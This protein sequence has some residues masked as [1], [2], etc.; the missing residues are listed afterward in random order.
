MSEQREGSSNTIPI[1]LAALAGGIIGAA[2]GIMLAPKAG[3]ELR[4]DLSE[5]AKETWDHLDIIEEGKDLLKDLRKALTDLR[6]TRGQTRDE[7]KAAYTPQPEEYPE[8][9]PADLE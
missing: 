1:V 6:E 8:N 9:M 5:K 2:A 4:H 3:K 7:K